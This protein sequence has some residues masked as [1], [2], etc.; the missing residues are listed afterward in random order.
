LAF[1]KSLES[2]FAT[3][4]GVT[5]FADFGTIV[6]GTIDGRVEY[7]II[8]GV[9]VL[10]TANAAAVTRFSQNPGTVVGVP[11]TSIGIPATITARQFCPSAIASRAVNMLAANPGGMTAAD[12]NA[13][14]PL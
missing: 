2:A 12:P 3:P 4:D 8:S 10:T 1:F 7:S 14:E 5:G 11:G 9:Q 6:N 13:D